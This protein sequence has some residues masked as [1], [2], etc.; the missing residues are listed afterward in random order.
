METR[1]AAILCVSLTSIFILHVVGQ[2]EIRAFPSP[3]QQTRGEVWPCE[4]CARARVLQALATSI[5]RKS[6]GKYDSS[7]NLV[8]QKI[9]YGRENRTVRKGAISIMFQGLRDVDC[10]ILEF[11]KRT[12]RQRA[13]ARR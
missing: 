13:R 12:Y 7:E 5:R 9:E 2:A 8:P 11:A 3:S 6:S 1:F 4:F 10:D